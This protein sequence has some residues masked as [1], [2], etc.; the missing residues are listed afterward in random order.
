MAKNF[1]ESINHTNPQIQE[2][3]NFS[4]MINDMKSMSRPSII[5]W[6][7]LKDGRSFFKAA[8]EKTTFL[9]QLYY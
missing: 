6:Q 7:S 8:G 2:G 5:K 9:R 1:P 3:P 4:R